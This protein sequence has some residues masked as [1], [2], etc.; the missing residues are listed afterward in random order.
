MATNQILLSFDWRG[1]LM[2]LLKSQQYQDK[3]VAKPSARLGSNRG[4]WV[5][6]LLYLKWLW[7]NP[8][9]KGFE[10]KVW[11][12]T[13][14]MTDCRLLVIADWEYLLC[15]LLTPQR[16]LFI[17]QSTPP[18]SNQ[19]PWPEEPCAIL[20]IN[21]PV[22]TEKGQEVEGSSQCW[23]LDLQQRGKLFNG[24]FP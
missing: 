13:V 9:D 21:V 23:I 1:D 7:V 15:G 18:Y 20:S 2:G 11:E 5:S 10:T 17:H 4:V 16:L 19:C 22:I 12:K 14:D 24:C 6:V 3:A 8:R